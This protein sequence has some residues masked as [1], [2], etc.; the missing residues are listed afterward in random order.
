MKKHVL[1]LLEYVRKVGIFYRVFWSF[2]ILISISAGFLTFFVYMKYSQH[3]KSHLENQLNLLVQNI[4]YKIEETMDDY[5]NLALTFYDNITLMDLIHDTEKILRDNPSSEEILCKDNIRI[6]EEKLY[7]I[8]QENRYLKNVQF[9][10]ENFQ[11]I[12][13]DNSGFPKGAVIKDLS[14]FY[15]SDFYEKTKEAKGY[16]VWFE[17]K[18]QT[19]LFFKSRQNI[20]G[21]ADI[22]TMTVSVYHQKTRDFLGILIFN[23]DL[24]A[25]ENSLSGLDYEKNGN[26]F[27]VGKDRVLFGLN[28]NMNAPSFP[29]DFNLYRNILQNNS[30]VVY[31]DIPEKDLI[32]SIKPI[33]SSNLS[34][35]YIGNMKTLQSPIVKIR[36]LCLQIWG[37]TVIFSGLIAYF[38]T[39]SISL[40]VKK[41]ISNFKSLENGVWNVR[42]ENSG[43]DEI[44][45]LGDQYN[46]MLEKMEELVQEVY[47]SEIKRQNLQI[48]LK[49]AQLES[50][51]MQ[52]NP[53]F[54]YNTLDIIRWE[55]MYEAKGENSVTE[56]IEKFSRLCRMMIQ[57]GTDTIPLKTVLDHASTYIDVINFRHNEK[58]KLIIDNHL[59]TI[60]VF[61][62]RFLI[63]PIM[64]N[65]IVHAFEC[66]KK[67]CI[68][69]IL[70][71]S[72]QNILFLEISDN[73]KGMKSEELELLRKHLSENETT[74]KSIGLC[75]IHQR[76][77]L[78]YGDSYGITPYSE[79]GKGTKIVIKLPLKNHSEKMEDSHDLPSI[80]C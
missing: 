8:K 45:T 52:I 44:T 35:T 18:E 75:N 39:V 67:D 70:C 28:P 58:I 38:I 23:I 26:I 57:T 24:K 76:L 66:K 63:Q 12:M 37:L 50:L 34:V 60:D 1:S 30:T 64:E 15:D 5:E 16:P 54:L 48:N 69:S 51:F 43:N 42:Y 27:L 62:P 31:T 56:M 22:I 65:T 72:D 40:P 80:D 47:L 41:L 3:N 46:R 13:R 11:Y 4:A 2:A 68:I 74:K 17:G 33:I 10:S 77:L 7:Y 21:L 29:K 19:E 6:I 53:H 61:V 32:F 20:Y 25:F 55:A 59:E 36:N 71:H 9:I 14:R 73:G 49:N 78:F 79:D